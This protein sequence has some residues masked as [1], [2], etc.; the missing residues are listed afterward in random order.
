MAFK[1]LW[2]PVCLL[3][4]AIPGLFATPLLLTTGGTFASYTPTD[5]YAAPNEPWTLSFEID[6]NPVVSNVTGNGFDVAFSDFTYM[7]NGSPL[8]L[9]VGMIQF[10]SSV[11]DPGGFDVCFYNMACT[12]GLEFEGPQLYTGSTSAP[13]IQAGVYDMTR[14]NNLDI[15]QGSFQQFIYLPVTIATTPEPSTLFTSGTVI[16]LAGAARL[17]KRRRSR[18]NLL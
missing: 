3:L 9:P 14:V 15:A 17:R 18:L 2:V 5:A 10:W 7:L 1:R 6:S 16:L 11:G 12:L 13:T 4:L 8:A